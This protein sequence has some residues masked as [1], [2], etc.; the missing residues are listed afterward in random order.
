[1]WEAC[2]STRLEE[3]FVSTRREILG[4]GVALGMATLLGATAQAGSPDRPARGTTEGEPPTGRV[5]AGCR[6]RFCR[7]HSPDPSRHDGRGRCTAD[8]LC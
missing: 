1:M 2:R 6:S 7:Y 3:R 8:V 4:L 5:A